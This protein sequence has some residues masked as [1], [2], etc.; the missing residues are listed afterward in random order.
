M[1]CTV[2]RT[3]ISE[4]CPFLLFRKSDAFFEEVLGLTSFSFFSS[5][6]NVIFSNPRI[7][8]DLS[9]FLQA[10]FRFDAATPSRVWEKGKDEKTVS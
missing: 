4:V 2:Y 9:R 7:S 8:F 6:S 3:A 5:I 10:S 1:Y